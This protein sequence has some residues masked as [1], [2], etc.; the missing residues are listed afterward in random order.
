MI[1]NTIKGTARKAHTTAAGVYLERGYIYLAPEAWTALYGLSSSLK[2][3]ASEY[4]AALLTTDNGT[5]F[6]DSKY[7]KTSTRNV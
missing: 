1:Q 2:L 4:L 3:S 5:T 6:K 7:D